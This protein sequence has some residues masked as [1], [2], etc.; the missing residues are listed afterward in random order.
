MAATIMQQLAKSHEAAKC[1]SASQ[2]L[3][4]N[5]LRLVGGISIA[6]LKQYYD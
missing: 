3:V 5:N 4:S 6:G 2:L 1:V